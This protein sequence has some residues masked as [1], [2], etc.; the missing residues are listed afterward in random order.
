[1]YRSRMNHITMLF[2][3]FLENN[4]P[5]P[6]VARVKETLKVYPYQA[7]GFG[8]SVASFLAGEAPLAKTPKPKT[9]RFVE[10]SGVAINTVPPNDFGHYEMLNELVQMEPAEAL[11]PELAGQ[12]A[13]IGIVKGEKFAPDARMKKILEKAVA[14][15]NAASRTL[16]TGSH[17]ADHYRYYDESSAWWNMLFEGGYEF[18]N[19]PPAITKKGVKPAPNTGARRLHSR[20][21]FFYTATGITPAMCMLLENVGSQ[22]LIANVDKNGEPF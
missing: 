4:D 3:A 22:Y 9:P 16:G 17:P 8:T 10:G 15:G 1:M 13:A 2:R 20:T 11:D 19:P 18:L 21:S 12:F 5:A 14:F 6:S 7:G